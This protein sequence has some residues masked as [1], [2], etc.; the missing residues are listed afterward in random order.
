MKQW[1]LPACILVFASISLAMLGS[2]RSDLL[3]K[4][5]LF[6]L[7][8]GGVFYLASRTSF[9]RWL[10]WRWW[11]YVVVLVL[12]ALPLLLGHSSRN[13]SRWIE[14]GIFR[15]QP[16][17][18]ALPLVGL[19]AV[20][21]V[22]KKQLRL[23]NILYFF[24]TILPPMMLIFIAPDLGTMVV[25]LAVLLGVL[26][27]AGIS[28]RHLLVLA[29]GGA[30]VAALSWV[31]ILKPY[32]QERMLSFIAGA[33][34]EESQHYNAAQALIAIGGGERIGT[35]WGKGTQAHLQFL[36]EAQTDFIF[37]SYSQEYGFVGTSF[38]LVLILLTTL[39]L[40][41]YALN[42]QNKAAYL[43]AIMTASTLLLQ[44]V[45]NIGMNSGLLPITGVTLPLISYGGS[46]ILATCLMLGITQSVLN[47]SDL[48]DVRVIS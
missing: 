30:L 41:H 33:Q 7:I 3:P 34:Q 46:S 1:F 11:L 2:V 21:L 28:F 8:G 16:S 18:L 45:V 38:L 44:A 14:L 12:L 27:F 31:F 9:T 22:A 6:F 36:P 17:Q 40:F 39:L 42:T 5:A 47:Q 15:L 25:F 43:Y 24:A 29:A 10:E 20:W 37:S 26:W 48:P 4:Q 13:T 19:S 32:Q 35:G 23:T